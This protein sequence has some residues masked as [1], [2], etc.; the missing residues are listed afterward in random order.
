M[1]KIKPGDILEREDVLRL[2]RSEVARAGGQVQWA[3]K[4]GL[5]RTHVNKILQGAKPL[6]KS[7]IKALKLRVVFAPDGR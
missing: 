7:A 2:L 1:R 4:A 6:S 3:K 5:N